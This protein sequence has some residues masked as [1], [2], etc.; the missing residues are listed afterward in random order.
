MSHDSVMITPILQDP[1]LPLARMT[2]IPSLMM[3]IIINFVD[4]SSFSTVTSSCQKMV[5]TRIDLPLTRMTHIPI[6]MMKIII[7]FVDR[8]SFSVVTS[9]CQK[10]VV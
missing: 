6:S 1:K 2:H 10:M 5:V 7:N 4:R 3:K 8:S 9:S